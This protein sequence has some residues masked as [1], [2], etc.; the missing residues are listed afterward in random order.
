VIILATLFTGLAKEKITQT[1]V[2][3][4]WKLYEK[5]GKPGNDSADLWAI[6]LA[7]WS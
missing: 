4:K 7:G 2:A 1:G 5:Y 6:K 3:G